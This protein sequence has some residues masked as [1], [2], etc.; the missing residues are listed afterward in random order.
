MLIWLF[1]VHD[2]IIC[3]TAAAVTEEASVDTEEEM[4]TTVLRRTRD[5]VVRGA[6]MHWRRTV[7]TTVETTVETTVAMTAAGLVAAGGADPRAVAGRNGSAM[8]A[9]GVG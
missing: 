7:A 6:G 9:V 1:I 8:T 3:L 2:N 4:R 5:D